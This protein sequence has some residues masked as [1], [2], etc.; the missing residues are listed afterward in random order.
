MLV[1]LSE[2]PLTTGQPFWIG[3]HD[4][5]QICSLV[6]DE[7][8]LALIVVRRWLRGRFSDRPYMVPFELVMRSA[9]E[10]QY[11]KEFKRCL[12]FWLRVLQL[13]KSVVP[14]VIGRGSSGP[15]REMLEQLWSDPAWENRPPTGLFRMEEYDEDEEEVGEEEE[16]SEDADESDYEDADETRDDEEKTNPR[17]EQE[18]NVRVRGSAS[19]PEP[20]VD[21]HPRLSRSFTR[22]QGANFFHAAHSLAAEFIEA[23]V[24]FVIAIATSVLY[25]KFAL[26]LFDCVVAKGCSPAGWR[27]EVLTVELWMSG[28]VSCSSDNSQLP[29]AISRPYG[30]SCLNAFPVNITETIIVSNLALEYYT[31]LIRLVKGQPVNDAEFILSKTKSPRSLNLPV[32]LQKALESFSMVNRCRGRDIHEVLRYLLLEEQTPGK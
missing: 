12:C 5:E 3:V 27:S 19:A 20:F 17:P 25:G 9:S 15:Q 24:Y 2:V 26:C 13:P 30:A 28:H 23:Q 29:G 32:Q 31:S 16:D 7:Y 6:K 21:T 1:T 8:K 10:S 22:L 4:G 14:S 18:P 11:R